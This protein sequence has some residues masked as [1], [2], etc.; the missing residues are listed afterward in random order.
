MRSRYKAM[1]FDMDGTLLDSM[2]YWRTIWRE[3]IES[4]G[5]AMPEELRG[6][7]LFGCGKACNLIARDNGLDRDAVYNEMLEE[8]LARHYREDVEPKPFAAR[9]LRRF[10]EAGFA[11]VVATATPR[12]MAKPAL[13]RHGLLAL[14]DLVTD[15]REMGAQKSSPAFFVNVARRLSA[16]P[17]A[18]V[19]F[20]DAVY[21]M[22]SAKAAGM[23]VC[24]VDEP[25]SY[26][27]KAEIMALADK[28]IM[29]WREIAEAESLPF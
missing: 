9:A 28:Y 14:A 11:V 24:A 25:I 19:M 6:Q 29:G 3:Y 16:E 10:R 27:D 18:C 15:V 8:F 23:T 12:H 21:A 2:I 7:T 17:G 13:A 1:V 4:R 26:P 20:E 22:R 5:L